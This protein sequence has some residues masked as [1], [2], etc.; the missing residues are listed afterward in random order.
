MVGVLEPEG[1]GN[2]PPP[3]S[4]K[5]STQ[6]FQNRGVPM[7]FLVSAFDY[8]SSTKCKTLCRGWIYDKWNF[9]SL[10][11]PKRQNILNLESDDSNSFVDFEKIGTQHVNC[12]SKMKWLILLP[13]PFSVLG[14]YH[15]PRMMKYSLSAC[16]KKLSLRLMF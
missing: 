4:G 2:C 9:Y 13:Y 16:L 5:I 11:P 8:S 1:Q 10:L 6:L 12:I 7:K 3:L 14:R 15:R